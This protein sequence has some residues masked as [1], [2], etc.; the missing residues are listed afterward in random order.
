MSFNPERWLQV[1]DV[2]CINIPKVDSEALLR[3]A[4]NRTYYA[5]LLSVKRRIEKVQGKGAVPTSGTH[6]ALMQALRVAGPPF[7]KIYRILSRLQKSRN[8]ADYEL[9]TAP[10]VRSLVVEDITRCRTLIYNQIN[11][12]RDDEFRTLIIPRTR[13]DS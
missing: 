5:G 12:V 8:A 1:A 6:E 10:L 9:D 2:C 13:K 3:T 4:V 11:T 7:E